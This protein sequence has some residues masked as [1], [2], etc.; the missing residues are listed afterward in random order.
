MTILGIF[1][2]SCPPLQT[3]LI[4]FTSV[5]HE[6]FQWWCE[7]S[8]ESLL[9]STAAVYSVDT[10]YILEGKDLTDCNKIIVRNIEIFNYSS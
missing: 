8:R 5:H 9:V 4:T 2:S 6:M 3:V 7:V 1:S 10:G